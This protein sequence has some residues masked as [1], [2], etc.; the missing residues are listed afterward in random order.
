MLLEQVGLE[1]L[2]ADVGRGRRHVDHFAGRPDG[3]HPPERNPLRRGAERDL[4]AIGF[5]R[6]HDDG[7]NQNDGER[8]GTELRR[9]IVDI[10]GPDMPNEET[11]SEESE[12]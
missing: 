3:Q 6:V 10:D 11:E 9:G 2:A 4:P 5:D 7:G 1:R 8:S 12:N